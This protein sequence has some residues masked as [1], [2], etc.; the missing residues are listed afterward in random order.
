MLEWIYIIRSMLIVNLTATGMDGGIPI[1]VRLSDAYEIEANGDSLT[2]ST[3]PLH[4]TSLR[5]IPQAPAAS[6]G[7]GP[8]TRQR[9]NALGP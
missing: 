6:R 5:P 2:C 7:S 9:A 8:L 1:D 3:G 4:G